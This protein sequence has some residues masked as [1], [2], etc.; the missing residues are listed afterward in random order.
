M[1]TQTFTAGERALSLP[2]KL[3]PGLR[4]KTSPPAKPLAEEENT[5]APT[6]QE[7]HEPDPALSTLVTLL[8]GASGP[9]T[10]S[11]PVPPTVTPAPART[12]HQGVNR[13]QGPAQIAS[14]FEIAPESL[15]SIRS[16]FSQL[17]RAPGDRH[18]Q[19]TLEV[20]RQQLTAL[21]CC[22]NS[23]ELLAVRNILL[24]LE[25]LLA[26]L[27]A[28]PEDLT[29]STLRT[30]AGTLLLL[31]TLSHPASRPD[32]VIDPPIRLLVVDDDP[33]S[34]V[35]MALALKKTFPVPDIAAA[36]DAALDFAAQDHYDVIF[37]DIEM[38]KM[39]GWEFCSKVRK[40]PLDGTTPVIFVTRS[41]DFQSRARSIQSGGQD[42]IAKPFLRFE[43]AVKALTFAIRGRLECLARSSNHRSM[44]LQTAGR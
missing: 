31:D 24:S 44:L 10:T 21:S 36:G 1:A 5:P 38:P 9:V 2:A 22:T 43:I 30:I 13:T 40:P 20:F 33:V 27:A 8:N 41:C 29:A 19:E 18:R 39:N 26:Q 23:P 37:A 14:Y 7:N 42:L 15:R 16:S 35:T 32:L 6:T 17:N 34:R 12:H 4:R 28:K 25:G 3:V 11:A